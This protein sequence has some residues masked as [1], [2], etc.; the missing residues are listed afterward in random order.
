MLRKIEKITGRRERNTNVCFEG[1][2]LKKIV[3]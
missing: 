2:S 3:P 1:S